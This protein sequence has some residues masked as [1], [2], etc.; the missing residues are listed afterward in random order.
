M[1]FAVAK[2]FFDGTRQNNIYI[3]EKKKVA[4]ENFRRQ[5]K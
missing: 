3:L 4:I 5:K 2:L 1:W